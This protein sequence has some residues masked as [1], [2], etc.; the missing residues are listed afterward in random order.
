MLGVGLACVFASGVLCGAAATISRDR[1][2]VH[3]VFTPAATNVTVQR[4][5]TTGT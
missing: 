1:H 5:G 2:Q 3:P 4:D